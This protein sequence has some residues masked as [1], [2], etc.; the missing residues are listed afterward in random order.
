[1]AGDQY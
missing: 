1:M